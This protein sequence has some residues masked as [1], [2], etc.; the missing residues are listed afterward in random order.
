[1]AQQTKIFAKGINFKRR[2]GAPDFVIGNLNIKVDEAI[3]TLKEN[4][5]NGWVNLDILT[6]K[7]GKPY[8]EVNTWTPDGEKKEQVEK[9]GDLP[10]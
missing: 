6:S 3:E 7:E 8:V 1:M 10:F 2:E 9:G 5:N 4:S